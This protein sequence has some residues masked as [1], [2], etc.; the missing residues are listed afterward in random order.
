MYISS[1]LIQTMN[2]FS[3]A[4]HGGAGTI[5]KSSI[6]QEQEAAYLLALNEALHIGYSL[7]EKGGSALDAVA[8]AV[9][10]LENCILFNA[11]K[12][13]VFTKN[14]LHEMDAAIM[15]GATMQAGA[16][17]GVSNVKNPVLLALKI[18]QESE[19]VMLSGDGA[20]LFMVTNDKGTPLNPKNWL[21]SR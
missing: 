19:H 8:A 10:S 15:N 18:M 20:L 12:G 14:G 13:S 1:Y 9:V 6:T 2:T 3:I 5:L 11:G 16:V 4:V 7:L 21:K 17:A